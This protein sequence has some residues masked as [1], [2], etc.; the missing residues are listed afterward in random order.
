MKGSEAKLLGFMEGADKR[1]V[2]PVY[3]RKY[4]WKIGNC[5]QL[6]E[7]LKK[8]IR[9][10]R[11][12]H[13]FGSI[14]SNVVPEGSKIEFHII[15]G[16]QRLTTLTLLLLAISNLV[17]SGRV[18]SE[19]TDLNEQIMQRFII[20]PWAKNDDKIKLRPVRE[21][22]VALEKLFGPVEDYDRG[23]N[24]TINYQ[25]F[26]DQ[27]LKE[28]VTVDE[29]YDAIGKLE[30]ISI[31][32]DAGDNAQL[33]FESL[34]STGLALQ[35]GD[36]IR[37][38]ILMGMTPKDQDYYYD[39]FW[40]KIEKCTANDVSGFVR[41][42]LSIKT[43]VTPTISNVYQDFKKY[44]EEVRL[45]IETLL[46]DLLRYARYFEK[47]LTCESGL[48]N[49]KLDD[50]LYRLKR[51]DVVVTRPFFMEVLRLNQDQKLSVDDVFQIFEITENYLFRR[52]ICEVPTNALNK[53][54][55][56]LNR[57]IYRYDNTSQDY[58]SKFV[59][60]LLSKRE[61]G[62]FPDDAEF[63]TAL[64]AK[65]VYQ[66]RGKYKAY[67]FERLENYG[68]IEAKDVYTHL[69]NNV[70]TIEH[71]MPQHLTPAWV[72]ALGPN[73]EEIHTIWLHRLA[74]LT[75]T[76]YNPSLSNNPFIEKRDAEKG[77]YKASGLRMN[78]KIAGKDSWGLHELEERNA[79]L[80]SYAKKIWSYPTTS[81]VPA[82]KEFDSCTLDDENADLT[83]RDIVKYRYQNLEQPV[84]SWAD[85][86][87]RVI[88]FLHQKDKSILSGL[89]Y[90]QSSTT[91][92][93]SYIS[94]DPNKLRSAIRVDEDIY[95]EKGTST[96]QKLSILRR[97]FA[98]YDLDPMDLVFYLRD[99]ENDKVTDENRQDLRK[100]YWSYALPLI[101]LAHS[102]RGSFSN[103]TPGTSNWCS[104][105]FGVGGF[106]ISCIAN[107]TEAWVALWMSSGDAAKNKRGFDILF[108]HKEE[109]EK[110]IENTDLNWD[111]ANEYKASWISYSL[112]GVSVANEADW[113][114]MAKF[115]AEWSAKIA[116]A[117]IPYLAELSADVVLSPEKIEKN[118]ALYKLSISVKEWASNRSEKGEISVNLS[119]SNRTYTRF[120]SAFMDTIIPDVPDT[121]SGWNTP[122]HY[123][124]EIINQT[125]KS[126]F[127]QLAISSKEMPADQIEISNQINTYYPSKEADKVN[128]SYRVPFKTE[129]FSFDD[130]YDKEAVFAQLDKWLQEIRVFEE[131]LKN[132]L[133]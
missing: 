27:I 14:V 72:E 118:K 82:E 8:I 76:G 37:N 60:A 57:E 45:P 13:F 7:D 126:L 71:I 86:L 48:N 102:H 16:Q 51:L 18:H 107:F 93:V 77:G 92:L 19:E 129:E 63:T 46:G 122:N 64:E 52:N 99:E 28:E 11:D 40:T 83:G 115:H 104:G 95:F 36:K 1:Y 20:A 78:Q 54:F 55:L 101:Q 35:E 39:T 75:L 133:L 108:E 90:S 22:R 81:F 50:C 66:M 84:T 94:T 23:S 53:I 31:T 103:V 34:N 112:K 105:Y 131:D 88:K 132:K 68:T 56:N 43:L 24:L 96:T 130:I 3:Q 114:R 123:F 29:L 2:I 38:Y 32:L 79:E 69:D 6:Y 30:I 109:I 67:L 70:Y 121:K 106:S 117:L 15:D 33:I 85:M 89:A 91:E 113:P 47:L 80:L 110:K 59:Y 120:R 61:S 5:S 127:V 25:F 62:R 125:G 42:Y 73:A 124:Y 128:W 9:D 26:Y 116:D 74:N 41:D 97:L 12:S 44:A 98:L 17:K 49:K 119:K 4:D 10:K 58:V 100:R 111:R 65:S 87:E 21:D